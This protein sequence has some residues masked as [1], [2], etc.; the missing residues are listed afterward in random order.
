MADDLQA[1]L[2]GAKRTYGRPLASW[3]STDGPAAEE[4]IWEA[5]LTSWVSPASLRMLRRSVRMEAFWPS[6]AG[7]EARS[8]EATAE[9]R[10]IVNVRVGFRRLVVKWRK[11]HGR[12]AIPGRGRTAV[13]GVY[14]YLHM[15]ATML[16]WMRMHAWCLVTTAG[17]GQGTQ[18]DLP[19]RTDSVAQ[20]RPR[21]SHSSCVACAP[22]DV[23]HPCLSFGMASLADACPL[24]DSSA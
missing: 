12:G 15:T 1:E 17:C 24:S 16:A 5:T 2:S 23:S 4:L 18:D 13:P 6:T 10:R 8:T 14:M 19:R 21:R 7:A 22:C 20:V 9:K 11:R 3:A